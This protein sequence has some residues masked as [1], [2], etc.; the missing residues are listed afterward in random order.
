MTDPVPSNVGHGHVFPRPDG[1]RARCGGPALCH[2]CAADLARKNIEATVKAEPVPSK[3]L[4]SQ[5]R[6][7]TG[8]N[9]LLGYTA[10]ETIEHQQAR[11]DSLMLEHSPEEMTTEQRER[12]GKHQ[13]PAHD[14]EPPHCSTCAC[15]MEPSKE[16]GNRVVAELRDVPKCWPND[17]KYHL[18]VI[19]LAAEEIERLEQCHREGWSYAREVEDEYKRR[20]GH[21]FGEQPTSEP[22]AVI[23][24]DEFCED[25]CILLGKH[26]VC[27]K[28][29]RV[30]K[31]AP[32][33]IEGEC[34][35]C[36]QLV[37]LRS[38]RDEVTEGAA[39]NPWNS[40]HAGSAITCDPRDLTVRLRFER[41]LEYQQMCALVEGA[42]QPPRDG[43]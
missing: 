30:C 19:A 32:L 14:R 43:Q 22:N 16:Q 11:I 34:P 2:V 33:Q 37:V 41:E 21:G 12:W 26:D 10:A 31:C 40:P 20:T 15:G 5:L 39:E 8:G 28:Q 29:E 17:T 24:P 36:S 18:E 42:A 13:R 1:V 25:G 9:R 27:L 7:L 6:A 35:N 3:D 38:D 4:C 23:A